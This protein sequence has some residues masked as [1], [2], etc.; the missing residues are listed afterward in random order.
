M[1]RTEGGLL[2]VPPGLI[3]ACLWGL[4]IFSDGCAGSRAARAVRPPALASASLP[5]NAAPARAAG[6]CAP[7]GPLR[8]PARP[9]LPHPRLGA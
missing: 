2:M 4:L 7:A 8:Q 6:R 1:G 3:V 9:L 5:L